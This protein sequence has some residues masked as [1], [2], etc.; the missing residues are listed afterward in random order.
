MF[1]VTMSAREYRVRRSASHYQDDRRRSATSRAYGRRS[2]SPSRAGRSTPQTSH[3]E[4]D[5]RRS[6]I[7]GAYG[8]RSRT[9]TRA[10][11]STPQTRHDEDGGLWSL[12]SSAHG[13]QSRSPTRAARSITS[14]NRSQDQDDGRGSPTSRAPWLPTPGASSAMSTTS[15]QQDDRRSPAESPQHLSLPFPPLTDKKGCKAVDWREDMSRLSAATQALST[16]RSPVKVKGGDRDSSVETVSSTEATDIKINDANDKKRFQDFHATVLG[17]RLRSEAAKSVD[18]TSSG[19]KTDDD[20]DEDQDSDFKPAASKRKPKKKGARGRPANAKN[21]TKAKK[22]LEAEL[23]V[24]EQHLQELQSQ[25]D[26]KG[27]S[28]TPSA[29]AP[30]TPAL[31]PPSKQTSISFDRNVIKREEILFRIM[32]KD[33]NLEQ[34]SIDQAMSCL[35][36]TNT[37]SWSDIQGIEGVKKCVREAV[38]WPLLRPDV[39]SGARATAKGIML[40]GPPGTGKSEIARCVASSVKK[41]AFFSVT[42]SSITSKYVGEGEKA[43]RALF[44]VARAA[45]P[46]IIFIDEMEVLFSS[47]SEKKHESGQHILTEFLA[48][49]DGVTHS[50]QDSN[51]VV[52]GATNR[53]SMIDDA[54]LRRFPSRLYVPLPDFDARKDMLHFRLSKTTHSLTPDEI[55]KLAVKLVGYS[56][57]DIKNLVSDACLE[58]VREMTE[59]DMLGV[60]TEDIRPVTVD[61]VLKA[62]QKVKASCN[63]ELLK[64][65]A[66]F[67]A[68]YG[69]LK[70]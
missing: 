54:I 34:K 47:R 23:R 68:K 20:Q 58:P 48:Q 29:P 66:A 10:G 36:V 31:P 37:V 5:H 9:P 22:E 13:R 63:T 14:P 3:Y 52:M 32:S 42:S 11:R 19:V 57:S 67:N 59:E 46:S 55:Q 30:S 56:G 28:S 35:L 8:P 24:K 69:S 27:R 4:D 39:F 60:A 61:D 38:V 33:L 53:P 6:A 45:S 18:L 7:S 51:V 15:P 65:Y 26:N 2:R 12:T 49:M 16:L 25:I 40:F 43:V 44:T 41:C 17:K 50:D 21:K 62:Q 1:T 64:E 70:P